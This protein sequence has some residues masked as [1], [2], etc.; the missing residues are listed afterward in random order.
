MYVCRLVIIG[1]NRDGLVMGSKLAVF[2]AIIWLKK[3][4]PFLGGGRD[5]IVDTVTTR[6]SPVTAADRDPCGKCG[7][8][9]TKRGYSIQCNR[10]AFWYHRESLDM[11]VQQIRRVA[12]GSWHCVCTRATVGHREPRAK[13]FH[14]YM[15]DISRSMKQDDVDGILARVNAHPNL[16]FTIE[17]EDGG[18]IPFLDMLITR[19][20]QRLYSDWYTKPTD[21][22]LSLSYH[23]CA[24]TRFKRNTV[25]GMVHRYPPRQF[26]VGGFSQRIGE[27]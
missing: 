12:V 11:N 19:S 23:A 20:D 10:C 5:Y 21:T 6:Q 27:S 26:Y 2:L 14:R 22:G 18:S 24:P 25:E 13:I 1:I 8:R 16:E 7:S 3:F 15:D 9:V 4:E 17:T